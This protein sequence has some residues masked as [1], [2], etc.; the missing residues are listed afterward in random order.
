MGEGR[1]AEAMAAYRKALESGRDYAE[2]HNNLGI[3]L[4]QWKRRRG[5][6]GTTK[7]P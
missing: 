4:G 5:D 2:A 6:Q 1:Q 7:R 3:A